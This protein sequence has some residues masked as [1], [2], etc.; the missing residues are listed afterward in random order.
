MNITEDTDMRRRIGIVMLLMVVG[1]GIAVGLPWML[2]DPIGSLPP[3]LRHGA[4]VVA[5]LVCGLM[6]L[7]VEYGRDRRRA[8]RDQLR[9]LRGIDHGG[10]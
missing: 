4:W 9:Q 1:A 2:G 10:S 6:W 3:P 7:G 8:L 5:A